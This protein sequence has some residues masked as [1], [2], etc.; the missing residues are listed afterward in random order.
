MIQV[1]L[2][3]A[4]SNSHSPKNWKRMNLA[5]LLTLL[6]PTPTFPFQWN[7][8]MFVSSTLQLRGQFW[9]LP[10]SLLSDYRTKFINI[11]LY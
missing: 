2:A 5:G 4:A 1:K 11:S 8:G 3:T 6:Q 9:T 10:D 7:S